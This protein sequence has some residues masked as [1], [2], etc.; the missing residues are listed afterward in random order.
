MRSSVLQRVAEYIE[1]RAAEY[2]VLDVET[3]LL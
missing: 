2:L 3:E 1:G